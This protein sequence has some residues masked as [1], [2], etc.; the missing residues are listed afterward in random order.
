MTLN[1]LKAIVI[2]E[3]NVKSIA[4]NEQIIWSATP[5]MEVFLEPTEFKKSYSPTTLTGPSDFN[6]DYTYYVSV[7]DTLYECYCDD[8]SICSIDEGLITVYNFFGSLTISGSL[9]TNGNT[10]IIAIYY[11]T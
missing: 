11:T 7:N 5:E 1:E 9:F 6:P 2:P 10:Y 8:S 3:G 4:I